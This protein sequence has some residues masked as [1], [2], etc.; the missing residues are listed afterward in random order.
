M[1]LAT[2]IFIISI[3]IGCTHVPQKTTYMPMPGGK[4]IHKEC[5]VEV[6]HHSTIAHMEDGRA[7]SLHPNGSQKIHAKC[8]HKRLSAPVASSGDPDSSWSPHWFYG[9]TSTLS[10]SDSYTSLST[11]WTV[12]KNPS[13]TS[14]GQILY[15]WPGIGSLD[16]STSDIGQPV[17]AW[18]SPNYNTS[19]KA[20]WFLFAAWDSSATGLYFTTPIQTGSENKGSPAT[21]PSNISGTGGSEY[22]LVSEGD[23]ITGNIDFDP[24]QFSWTIK[25]Q[26]GEKNSTLKFNSCVFSSSGTSNC[27]DILPSDFASN[28]QS[29]ELLMETLK[30]SEVNDFPGSKIKFDGL[31]IKK[32]RSTTDI[33]PE[34]KILNSLSG[35]SSSSPPFNTTRTGTRTCCVTGDS[36]CTILPPS[37]SGNACFD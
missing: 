29:V 24:A 23:V 10:G 16:G 11:N 3:S 17:L 20:S 8:T 15:I 9:L 33:A 14:N 6:P 2:T 19:K 37:V 18:G 5:I 30:A 31:S 35:A 1:K 36:A 22:M 34:F 13:S 25:V 27:G 32:N 12:P 7:I 21:N 4:L 28:Q 26:G